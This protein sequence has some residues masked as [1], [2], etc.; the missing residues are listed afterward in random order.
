MDTE[1]VGRRISDLR[2]AKGMTQ[3]ELGERLGIT[4]QAVSKWGRAD[5]LS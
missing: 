2:R 4:F 5:S 1:A 3:A